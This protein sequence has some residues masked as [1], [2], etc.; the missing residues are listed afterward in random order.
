MINYFKYLVS[1]SLSVDCDRYLS[2][3]KVLGTGVVWFSFNDHV[4]FDCCNLHNEMMDH[5]Q[6]SL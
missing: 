2:N 5:V 1:V 3:V 6:I 4:L